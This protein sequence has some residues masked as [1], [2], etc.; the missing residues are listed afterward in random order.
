MKIKTRK[1]RGGKGPGGRVRGAEDAVGSRLGCRRGEG[2]RLTG[3]GGREGKR[4]DGDNMDGQ[5]GR[6]LRV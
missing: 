5:L 4:K 6:A 3:R 2:L 1:R